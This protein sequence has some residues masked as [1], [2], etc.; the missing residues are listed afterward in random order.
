VFLEGDSAGFIGVVLEG[1]VQV[2]RDDYH[3][4]RCVI[5]H[6]EKGDIF[7]EAYACANV[8]KMPVSGFALKNS[9]VLML[10]CRKMLT[11]CTGGCRFHNQLVK[12]LL[13]A[14]NT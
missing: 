2:V 8:E 11:V 4:D 7:G 5:A 10:S 9:T 14:E 1:V 3:G 6:A 12:N 13:T